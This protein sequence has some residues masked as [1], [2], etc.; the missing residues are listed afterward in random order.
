MKGLVN[1][2][3]RWFTPS[4]LTREL[5]PNRH[6][7]ADPATTRGRL[8]CAAK[9]SGAQ[10][11][12]SI[13]GNGVPTLI[14]VGEETLEHPFQPQKP[15]MRHSKLQAGNPSLCPSLFRMGQPEAFNVL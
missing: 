4:F 2:P 11:P 7:K 1:Q 9:Q 12:G 15:S 13:G 5:K 8:Y 6:K 14:L 10:L 3:E